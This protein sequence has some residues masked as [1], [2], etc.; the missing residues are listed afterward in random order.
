MT[1]EGGFAP[2]P[3]VV[4]RRASCSFLPPPNSRIARAKPAR[5]AATHRRGFMRMIDEVSSH[6]GRPARSGTEHEGGRGLR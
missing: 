2:L 5:G 6:L 4:A 1:P 3:A